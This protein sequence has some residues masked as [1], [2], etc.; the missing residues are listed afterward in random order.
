MKYTLFELTELKGITDRLRVLEKP[1]I[2]PLTDK[3]LEQL[4]KRAKRVKRVYNEEYLNRPHFL[5]CACIGPDEDELYCM[6]KMSELLYEYRYD[7]ALKLYEEQ[8]HPDDDLDSRREHPMY[9]SSNYELIGIKHCGNGNDALYFK[10]S[11]LEECIDE[12]LGRP[13]HEEYDLVIDEKI[14]ISEPDSILLTIE[15]TCVSDRRFRIRKLSVSN[16]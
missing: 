10:G 9:I 3:L 12:Y 4:V 5:G 7:V 6:C 16:Y 11:S 2:A 13:F 15:F 1:K 8:I 14:K